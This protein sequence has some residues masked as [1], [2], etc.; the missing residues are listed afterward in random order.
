LIL[1]WVNGDP[2]PIAQRH[3]SL[4]LLAKILF[5]NRLNNRYF[6]FLTRSLTLDIFSVDFEELSL[7]DVS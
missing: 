6:L 5:G 1:L 7:Y 2:P 4:P 3:K